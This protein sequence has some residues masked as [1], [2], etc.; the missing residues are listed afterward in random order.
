MFFCKI[1][2][3]NREKNPTYL[4]LKVFMSMCSSTYNRMTVRRLMR[5]IIIS[6]LNKVPAVCPTL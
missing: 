2:K 3:H 5:I 1:V 6:A 4:T